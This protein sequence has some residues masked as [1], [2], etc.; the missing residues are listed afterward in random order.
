MK[1]VSFNPDLFL[2][3]VMMPDMDGPATLLELRQISSL[4]NTQ[5]IFTAGHIEAEKTE[6]LKSPM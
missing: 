2:L 4:T 5:A 3:E 1:V 6:F